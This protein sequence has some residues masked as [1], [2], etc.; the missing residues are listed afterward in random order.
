MNQ[1][2][3]RGTTL[4]RTH[5]LARGLIGCWVMNEAT[6]NKVF[7]LSGQVNHGTIIGADWVFDGLDFV[8][9][10]TD[11][12]ELGDIDEIKSS[13]FSITIKFKLNSLGEDKTIITKSDIHAINKPLLIWYDT[14]VKDGYNQG[15]THAISVIVTDNSNNM[16]WIATSSNSVDTN[17]HILTV[18]FDKNTNRLSAYLDGV[19][20]A[21]YIQTSTG[22]SATAY[23][24]I[25][26]SNESHTILL[27]GTIGFNY[28]HNRAL[29]PTEVANLNTNPYQMFERPVNPAIL[30]YESV[31]G[32]NIPV[33]IHHYNQIRS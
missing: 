22:I 10:N 4:N 30:Y 27:D 3:M 12:V 31:G 15:N 33:F 17:P 20:E 29:S 7:D 23:N 25:I 24:L 32:V 28:I 8:A 1:K 13:S 21:T 26:G 2:P 16:N 6:G 14:D 9:A 19:L 11:Y 18:T 5:P